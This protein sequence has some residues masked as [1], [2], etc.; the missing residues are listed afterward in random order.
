MSSTQPSTPSSVSSAESNE[1]SG[2]R[3][4]F[5][6]F[7]ALWVATA[8]SLVYF[9]SITEPDFRRRIYVA[10]VVNLMLPLIAWQA[11]RWIDQRRSMD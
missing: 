6:L 1:P 4:V 2:K 9:A 7:A 3:V 10:L 5:W 11:F 8:V